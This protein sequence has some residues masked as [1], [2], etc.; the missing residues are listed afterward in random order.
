[1]YPSLPWHTRATEQ[2]VWPGELGLFRVLLHKNSPLS[3]GASLQDKSL[4]QHSYISG[5]WEH[6]CVLL[7]KLIHPLPIHVTPLWFN[8]KAWWKI[9]AQYKTNCLLS[10]S[11]FLSVSVSSGTKIYLF[12]LH[13][14]WLF[15]YFANTRDAIY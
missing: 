15:I 8:W 1:M 9:L 13:F 3:S 6:I 4:A 14:A 2:Q 7:Y 11:H 12:K 5:N 10:L